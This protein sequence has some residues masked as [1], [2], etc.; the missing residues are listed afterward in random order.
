M[1]TAAPKAV[2]VISSLVARGAIGLRA[3]GFALER[4][5]HPVWAVPTV[6]L[7]WHP[8]HGPSTRTVTDPANLAA[9][10]DELADSQWL[11]EVGAIVSGFLGAAEHAEAIASFVDRVKARQPDVLY[12]C[13]PV[14]GDAGGLY[15][16]ERRADAI[17]DTLI[18]RADIATPNRHEL[19][20]LTGMAT[21]DIG[22]ALAAARRLGPD[23]V[24][25]TSA[26]ALMR[27]SIATLYAT[28]RGAWAAEH[29][30]VAHPPH[31]PGDLSAGLLIDQV[32]ANRPDEAA[33]ERTAAGAFE[34]VAR[35]AKAGSDELTLVAD[36][37]RLP[38]PMAMVQMRRL[39]EAKA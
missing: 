38:R 1:D 8:G 28:P 23:R 29:P 13:D 26:P 7:P 21:D 24:L 16:P 17:R 6:F 15:I 34:I 27:N 33:L 25:V 10:L 32:L 19:A 37:G 2:I 5:G 9:A 18:P 36:Q 11:D 35:S 14:H 20:W 22:S 4:L 39:A 3:T 31:G 12:L 30:L